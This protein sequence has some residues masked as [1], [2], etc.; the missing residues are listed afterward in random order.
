MKPNLNFLKN[1]GEE[2]NSLE[3]ENELIKFAVLPLTSLGIPLKML[4]QFMNSLADIIKAGKTKI[5]LPISN[6]LNLNRPVH[7]TIFFDWK[8]K[9]LHKENKFLRDL[10]APVT[11]IGISVGVLAIIM[12]PFADLVKK[13]IERK[14]MV[15]IRNNNSASYQSSGGTCSSPVTIR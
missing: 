9:K 1:R 3:K 13:E 5:D 14:R 2:I 7:S 8:V 15:N 10:V 4:P 12:K 6:D 11:T